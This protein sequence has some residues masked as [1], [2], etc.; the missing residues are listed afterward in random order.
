M[1]IRVT[2]RDNKARPMDYYGLTIWV[3][4][5]NSAQRLSARRVQIVSEM[6]MTEEEYGDL[7]EPE[8]NRIYGKAFIGTIVTDI[9]DCEIV[10]T[11]DDDNEVVVKFSF[12]APSEMEEYA[13]QGEELLGEDDALRDEILTRAV[14]AE[15]YREAREVRALG[16]SKA[17]SASGG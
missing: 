15:H 14:N 7:S 4:Y 12:N 2:P 16:N 11:D 8:R 3:K 13:T 10:E 1:G 17:L 6:G 9:E 5:Q